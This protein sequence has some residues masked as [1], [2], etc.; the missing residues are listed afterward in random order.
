MLPLKAHLKNARVVLHEPLELPE[1][2]ELEV[3]SLHVVDTRDDFDDD[4]TRVRQLPTRRSSLCRPAT[5]LM[6]TK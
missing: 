2:T 6:A 1:N 4:R 5:P 3:R